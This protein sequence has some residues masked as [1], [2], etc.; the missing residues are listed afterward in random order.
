VAETTA[1]IHIL[2]RFVVHTTPPAIIEELVPVGFAVYGDKHPS[3]QVVDTL[4]R[5]EPTPDTRTASE[6]QD[7]LTE[8]I[9]RK[10]FTKHVDGRLDERRRILEAERRALREKLAESATD[11]SQ[12]TWLEGIDKLTV[13]S[14]D[15]LAITIFY[16]R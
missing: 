7:D 3:G 14:V 15:H 9:N 5:A 1:V 4:L 16:P 12:R 13:A 2:V 10:D 6:V 11:E 8:L